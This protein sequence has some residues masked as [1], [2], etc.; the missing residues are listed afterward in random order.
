MNYYLIDSY[1]NESYV[2][3]DHDHEP[4]HYLNDQK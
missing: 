4:S 2:D 1:Q 3:N